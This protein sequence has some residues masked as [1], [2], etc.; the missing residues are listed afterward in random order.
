MAGSCSLPHGMFQTWGSNAGIPHCRQIPYHLNHQG[1]PYE[2]IDISIIEVVKS[3]GDQKSSPVQR[4]S[5]WEKKGVGAL[6]LH[7]GVLRTW[8]G[9]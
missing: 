8:G 9:N 3:G 1:S 4:K 7:T 5:Q 6:L 2:D